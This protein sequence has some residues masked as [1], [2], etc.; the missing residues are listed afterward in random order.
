MPVKLQGIN[1]T[2]PLSLYL[3]NSL[4]H[5]Y[6]H[7]PN[8]LLLYFTA[9]PLPL[10]EGNPLPPLP[11]LVLPLLTGIPLPLPGAPILEAGFGVAN[12]GAEERDE[13]GGF[14]TNSVSVVMNV[15]SLSGILFI[16]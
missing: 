13:G 16:F 8:S 10:A 15:V 3:M 4:L 1:K 14:S 5:N 7:R 11:P 12:F 9:L 2:S 6:L